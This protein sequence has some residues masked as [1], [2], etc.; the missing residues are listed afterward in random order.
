LKLGWLFL[1][2]YAG[3]P[4]IYYGD[5][6]GI[7]GDANPVE[8]CRRSFL[9]EENAWD[10]NLRSYLKEA[11]ALRRHNPALC[12]GDFRRLWS[13]DGIYAFS[14]SLDDKTLIVSLNSSESPQQAEVMYQ[15]KHIPEVLF[16]AASN[17]SIDD[18]RLTFTVPARS[19]VVL[20]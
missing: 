5:E 3:A 1:L 7:D 4:C 15:P 11:I 6:I 20:G 10:K 2:T 12:R 13:M 8:N 14:R 16:G 9:W 17:M 18:G 19:G